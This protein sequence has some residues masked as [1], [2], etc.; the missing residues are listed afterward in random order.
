MERA[1]IA[2]RNS[3]ER[4][5]ALRKDAEA[6][7]KRDNF[8]FLEDCYWDM[9]FK[10]DEGFRFEAQYRA[11]QIPD[12]PTVIAFNHFAR[13]PWNRLSLSI[14][15][16]STTG[17]I[18][19]FSEAVTLQ[20]Q[21]LTDRPVVWISED[22]KDRVF[23]ITLTDRQTQLAA[24]FCYDSILVKKNQ[25]S[26]HP[27]QT[28]PNPLKLSAQSLMEGKNLLILPE[29]KTSSFLKPNLL[30]QYDPTFP[31]FLRQ[32]QKTEIPFQI[33]P[34]SVYA[35]GKIFYTISGES[36][37]PFGQPHEVAQKVMEAIA[38]NL[39]KEFRGPYGQIPKEPQP[40]NDPK[41]QYPVSKRQ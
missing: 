3:K 2:P 36:I 32:L 4:R 8:Q 9:L 13:P 40:A 12:L 14:E 21:K 6:G 19:L 30:H 18:I 41:R 33:L 7:V 11:E 27:D 20:A 39:P 25:K 29:G 31:I 17:D 37:Y 38:Q 26:P 24:A 35:R 23:G 5:A 28:R 1:E 22:I 34:V 15:S 10:Q 16:L